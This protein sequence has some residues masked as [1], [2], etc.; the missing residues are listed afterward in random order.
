MAHRNGVAGCG[1]VSAVL[2]LLYARIFAGIVRCGAYIPALKEGPLLQQCR[3]CRL[4]CI[5]T[6]TIRGIITAAVVPSSAEASA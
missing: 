1:V 3:Y 6:G 4:W 2:P 5:H